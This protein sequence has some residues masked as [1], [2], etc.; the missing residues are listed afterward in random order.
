MNAIMKVAVTATELA[1]AK[2]RGSIRLT[3]RPKKR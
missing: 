3:G 1:R 2:K